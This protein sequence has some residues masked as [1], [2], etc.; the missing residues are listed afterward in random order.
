M[1]GEDASFPQKKQRRRVRKE[2]KIVLWDALKSCNSLSASKFSQRLISVVFQ[3]LGGI[4]SANVRLKTNKRWNGKMAWIKNKSF[5]P[6]LLNAANFSS[7]TFRIGGDEKK[8]RAEEW[9]WEYWK[10]WLDLRGN[11]GD[12]EMKLPGIY[13]VTLAKIASN[14]GI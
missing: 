14:G 12:V 7:S 2:R 1:C 13:E 4:G 5:F 11:E 10:R 9:R 6:N 3:R 8:E